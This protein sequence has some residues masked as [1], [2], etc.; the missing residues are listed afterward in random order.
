MIPRATYRVQFHKD[1]TFADAI[2]LVSYWAK[3]GISHLYSSPIATSRAGSTHG[4]DVVDP[5]R[6]DPE[7]GGEDG[8][9]AL[10]AA[11]KAQGLGIILDI[12]PNH[13]AVGHGDNAW[14]LDVL[15][16]GEASAFAEYF[17][18]DWHPDDP[19]L[20]GKLLAPFLGAPYGEALDNGDFGVELREGKAV[21][22]AYSEHVL[23][24]R[25]EDQGEVAGAPE[26]YVGDRLH[27]L[28]ERQHWRL[29]W[30]RT[31]AD[32][33]N[34]RR[35]FD[36][37]ELAGIRVE[38]PKVFDAVHALPL[39]L[40]AQGLIDG[41]RVDHVDGLAD[42]AAY[43]RTLRA[44]LEAAGEWRPADAAPGPAYLVV[45]KI[46][47][48]GE[49]LAADWGV[50]GTSGY[51]FMNAVSA[52][53]HDPAGAEPLALL[54]HEISGRPA[55]FEAEERA[56]RIE[57]TDLGFAGQRDAA[58]HAFRLL[59]LSDKAT[60]DLAEPALRRAIA[61][62][63]AVFPNYR[64]YGTG[65]A[66]PADDAAMREPA[67][68]AASALA[69]PL[70]APAVVQI[71]RWLAGEG[72]GDATLAADGVRRFQQLSAPIAA[73]AVED[74][75]FYRYGR[76]LSRND[77]GFDP[78]RLGATADDFLAEIARR[79]ARHPHAMLTT[80]THD[81][82]RGEDVR[83]RL[84]VISEMPDAWARQA[85]YW[86][87]DVPAEV[88]R[89]DAAMLHQMIVGGWPIDLRP[90]D[91]EGLAD[92]AERLSG[93]QEKALREAKLRS[94]WAL[95]DEDY[96]A[97]CK[98]YLFGL[99]T[100]DNP[101]A[102]EAKVFVEKI[103]A[104]GVAKALVQA[105]LRCTLPGVPDLFQGA[106][107]WDLSLVD[108]DNRRPVDYAALKASLADGSHPEQRLIAELLALRGENEVLFRDGDLV[109]VRVSG[110]RAEDALAFAR[111]H[112]GEALLV[113]CAIRS[114]EHDA[115]WWAD[116][117]LMLWDGRTMSAAEVVGHDNLLTTSR[118]SVAVA[119]L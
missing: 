18:I 50:D 119:M 28:C 6:I 46:L 30:W 112:E 19:A 67:V 29:A 73:K 86:A 24:I 44:R 75:A 32:M 16:K 22:V 33:I 105:A 99:L 55:A 106:E 78:A 81:H 34:W 93:W 98:A 45:E 25:P 7:L 57:M 64:T 41:V 116:T 58:A 68:T 118:G 54:W 5:A 4:Y 2:P 66:A 76:L 21:V 108:P 91:A 85:R 84:A 47:A 10:A 95:P 74:T 13:V 61:A 3:L 104:A 69:G 71:G 35:F 107:G 89:C 82:K 110:A 27:A 115:D 40:Y 77:V 103:A 92:F 90:D 38:E 59:A 72:P 49:E 63:L 51:D 101:F 37:I 60:R 52:V 9:K 36:I 117:R 42:P 113:L 26:A 62:L 102:A 83:A 39:R 48:Q 14:W 56:A 12:V 88:E 11:L 96:E 53:L 43:C 80:A 111:R 1:F 31:A 20:D 97:A 15:E 109:P 79:A 65:D 23:P 94:S 87:A 100:P 70:D 114:G 17:D 8:F